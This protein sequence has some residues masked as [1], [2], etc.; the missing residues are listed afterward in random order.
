[1]EENNSIKKSKD[2]IL[3][4]EILFI[5]VVLFIFL[6]MASIHAENATSYSD[7]SDEISN[8]QQSVNLTKD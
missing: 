1:M 3:S 5:F 2:I 6:S 7:L 8:H 4:K